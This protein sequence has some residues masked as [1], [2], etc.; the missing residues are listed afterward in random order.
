LLKD[1]LSLIYCT[2]APSKAV[3]KTFGIAIT[4]AVFLNE[5]LKGIGFSNPALFV[6]H[7]LNFT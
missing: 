7:C 5:I 3:D 6:P 2:H 1:A 4:R